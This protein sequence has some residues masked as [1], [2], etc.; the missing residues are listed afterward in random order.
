VTQ[1]QNAVCVRACVC[2]CT[3]VFFLSFTKCLKY[4]IGRQLFLPLWKLVFQPHLPPCLRLTVRV[5]EPYLQVISTTRCCHVCVEVP[6]HCFYVAVRTTGWW[7]VW[8]SSLQSPQTTYWY[9]FYPYI[10]TVFPICCS[11]TAISKERLYLYLILMI[12]GLMCTLRVCWSNGWIR[13]HL[14]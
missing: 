2:V 7:R 12:G 11:S 5:G 1:H 3:Y 14:W 10:A 4:S 13:Q 8:N 9:V 6:C